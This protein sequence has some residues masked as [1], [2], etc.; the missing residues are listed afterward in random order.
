MFFEIGALAAHQADV[1]QNRCSQKFRNIQKKHLCWSLFLIKLQACNF[2]VNIA[3]F[4]GG[5]LIIKHMKNEEWSLL[6]TLLKND[7]ECFLFH[8]ENSFRSVLCTL[9]LAALKCCWKIMEIKSRPLSKHLFQRTQQR[10]DCIKLL[11]NAKFV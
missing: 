1:L 8:L 5:A 3:K 6:F 2:S 7:E 11:S 10:G 4:L 9:V